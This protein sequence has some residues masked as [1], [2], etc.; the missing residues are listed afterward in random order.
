MRGATTA[1]AL[2]LAVGQ[3]DFRISIAGAQ[4]KTALLHQDGQWF[5]PKTS[6]PT[7]H[8]FKLPLG[9]I[10]GMKID[11]RN[12]IEN[13]WLCSLI[14][15]KFGVPVAACRPMQFEDMKALVEQRHRR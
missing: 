8:I 13:E 5:L 7:T 4:E 3:D 6:T 15:R 10:G 11:M 2:G 12:S 14:L 1:D 9:L